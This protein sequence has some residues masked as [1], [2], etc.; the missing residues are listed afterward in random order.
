MWGNNSKIWRRE[1]PNKVSDIQVNSPQLTHV[2]IP[3]IG[4]N[5]SS[6]SKGSPISV[7]SCWYCLNLCAS[8]AV[9]WLG[10]FKKKWCE[11]LYIAGWY[12]GLGRKE[13]ELLFTMVSLGNFPMVGGMSM[14]DNEVIERHLGGKGGMSTEGRWLRDKG[15]R[16]STIGVDG[17]CFFFSRKLV[18]HLMLL[19]SFAGL[20]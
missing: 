14:G 12:T 16:D 2:L 18:I 4:K 8:S 7:L 19:R 3:P 10:G 5:F 17:Q 9:S 6:A 11:A 13:V 1:N 20:W 15:D